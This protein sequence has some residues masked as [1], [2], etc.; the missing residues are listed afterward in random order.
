[1]P[2]ELASIWR[3]TRLEQPSHLQDKTYDRNN[4]LPPRA[5]DGHV[6]PVLL[7]DHLRWW[8]RPA[9]MAAGPA[10]MVGGMAT[11]AC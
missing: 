4:A 3:T 5:T 8:G 1:M 10:A 9:R 6:L 2:A 11:N 7:G